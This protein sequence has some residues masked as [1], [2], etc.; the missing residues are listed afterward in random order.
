MFQVCWEAPVQS[1]SPVSYYSIRACNHRNSTDKV[2]TNT[3]T[4][5]TSFNVT[6]LL[7]GTA[8]ELTVVAVSQ[9]GEVIAKSPPSDPVINSTGFT[10][11]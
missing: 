8:Y 2:V 1:D 9:G 3:L 4:N 10:G 7:P 11:Q 6:G 5:E